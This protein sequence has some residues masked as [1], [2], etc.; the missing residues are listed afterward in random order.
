MIAVWREFA[1]KRDDADAVNNLLSRPFPSDDL[2]PYWSAF[3]YL[4]RDRPRESISLGLGGGL[5]L[6][7]PIPVD[8]IRAEGARLGYSDDALEDFEAILV[9]IDDAFVETTVKKQAADAKAAAQKA[10]QKNRR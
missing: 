9:R 3:L 8:R 10:Q 5:S 7:R 4:S 1:E 6:E 2:A